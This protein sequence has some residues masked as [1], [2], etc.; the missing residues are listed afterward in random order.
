MENRTLYYQA[1]K[2]IRIHIFSIG[3]TSLIEELINTK[4]SGYFLI[5]SN[6]ILWKNNNVYVGPGRG[7]GVGS[8]VAYCLGLN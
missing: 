7:S 4:Y 2:I 5:V 8:L 3:K 6:F 1:Y